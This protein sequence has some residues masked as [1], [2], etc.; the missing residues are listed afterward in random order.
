MSRTRKIQ[1]SFHAGELTP[2]GWG[3][4]DIERYDSAVETLD[5]FVITPQGGIERRP[6][7]IYVNDAANSA[8]KS[9]LVR[10]EFSTVQAY[11]IEFS[12]IK[13][14][15]FINNGIIESAPGVPVEVVTPYTQSQL[16]EL[17]FTQSAD[18][19]YIVHPAHA[20]RK[21][22]RSS[23]TVWT[24][25][26]IDFVDG[27]YRDINKSETLTLTLSALT[28][29]GVTMTAAAALFD[30]KHVG[31]V[32]RIEAA[33]ASKNNEWV[34]SYSY[35][36][37]IR[38]VSG[39]RVYETAAG[40]TSGPR[41][42]THEIGTESDGTVSWTWK[43][44]GFGYVKVTGY[45]SATVVTVTVLKDLPN[46]V[47]SGTLKWREGAWSD[48][49][50]WPSTV[51]F[52]KERQVY[53]GNASQPQTV[54]FSCTNDF[55]KF[56][57][58]DRIDTTL[59]TNAIAVT[60][61]SSTVNSIAWMVGADDLVVGTIGG[62][63]VI[64][65][66]STSK[67]I[68]P[69]NIEAVNQTNYGSAQYV[70]AVRIG[71]GTLFV[72]RSA[73]RLRELLFSF[74]VDNYKANDISVLGEHLPRTGGGIIDVAYQNSPHSVWWG[75]REDGKLIG[76][77]YLREQN[78]IGWHQHAIGGGGVVESVCCIP[79]SDGSHDQ[80]WMVVKRTINGNEKRYIEVMSPYFHPTSKTDSAG[81][82]FLDCALDY[83]GAATSTISGLSH[84][85]GETVGVLV[86]N[87]VH[88]DKDVAS[89]AISLDT[90]ATSALVGFPYD[91]TLT[92]LPIDFSGRNGQ[93][94]G[95]AVR[96]HRV[97]LF[98]IDSLEM[99]YGS[100]KATTH[101]ENF[102]TP[103]DPMGSRPPFYTG[104]K[105]L[106]LDSNYSRTGQFTVKQSKPYPLNIVS[107][108]FEAGAYDI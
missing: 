85:E 19:L 81:M 39:G 2:L 11:V 102:R 77:T 73:R 53:G 103:E 79:A 50:G 104:Y 37:G 55:E 9:R 15:F 7:T 67:A 22:T 105:T 90:P 46:S 97:E 63:W 29:T 23:H 68:S 8:S 69:D 71:T 40:G 108:I 101:D 44:N 43:H 91:S 48:Y 75:I 84:L 33:S 87:A 59:D 30:P 14:R 38:V 41:K 72:E 31:S 70:P 58:T 62:E 21:L 52:Y 34:S 80:L 42:P 56:S 107:A 82:W 94:T 89:G 25:S 61:A 88:P 83:S 6:G 96:I 65:A 99:S 74:E 27:P 10:F 1:Q 28:G 98:L 3:R 13:A 51:T 16:R 76:C 18:Y 93:E 60:F 86:N 47:T 26:T 12:D 5:N 49:R 64:S 95:Q 36:A 17:S 35:S 66:A 106:F 20:P 32:W 24:L 57:P 78:I 100:G 54:W 92:T 4:T 45:T